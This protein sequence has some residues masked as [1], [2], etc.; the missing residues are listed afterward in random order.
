MAGIASLGVGSGLDLGSLVQRLVSAE[1]APA[2]SRLNASAS[3]LNA[4]I[5]AL[6][7]VKSGLAKL[8]TAL[9]KL[10]NLSDTRSVQV[11]DSKL[12]AVTA[13][14]DADVGSY[15]ITVSHLARAESRASTG[16]ADPDASL[17]TGELTLSVGAG[18]PVTIQIGEGED[19]LR[20]IRD[21]IND[22]EA[23]VSATLVKDG[24]EYRLLLSA[25]ETGLDSVI[26]LGISAG[27]DTRLDSANMAVTTA[28][29]DASFSVSGLALTSASNEIEDVLPGLTLT[30]KGTTEETSPLTVTVSQDVQT[31]RKAVDA[32]VTAYNGM[33]STADTLSKYDAESNRAATLT[34]DATLRAI[35]SMLPNSLGADTGGTF[36][37]VQLGLSSD[38]SGQLSL[39]GDAFAE[40]MNQDPQGV[41]ASLQGFAEALGASVRGYSDSS[42]LLDTKVEG[43]RSSL[44]SIDG[45][46]E[47]LANRMASFEQRLTR[48]FSALDQLVAQ[49]NSTGNYLQS[50]LESISKITK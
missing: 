32:F 46:R 38:V 26:T 39:D 13:D 29:Q 14:A 18:E 44:K 23:G 36:N 6:G 47:A 28:A 19:T 7:Q 33:I 1:R 34:G 20:G 21:A 31:A 24:E 43:M 17:G 2:E 45:Q 30:L 10:A 50:Q 9:E 49:L 16:F 8:D 35:R 12:V 42:G 11:S 3:R 41:I 37:A 5:S 40:L 48:Q 15:S 22:A 27:M 4:Q 25:A